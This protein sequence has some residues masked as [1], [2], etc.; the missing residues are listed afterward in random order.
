ML[1]GESVS[2]DS[3]TDW[4]AVEAVNRRA[5]ARP[6][7]VARVR[8]PGQNGEAWDMQLQDCAQFRA[9]DSR[10][11]GTA[12]TRLQLGENAVPSPVEGAQILRFK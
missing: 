6:E 4:A 11:Q 10:A 9:D 2:I 1:S 5:S 7:P 3:N 12:S 8:L